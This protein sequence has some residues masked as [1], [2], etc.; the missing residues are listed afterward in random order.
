MDPHDSYGNDDER[1]EE[2]GLTLFIY[3]SNLSSDGDAF[4]A[5]L[6]IDIHS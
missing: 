2:P 3:A 1:E 5:W 6:F 4:D